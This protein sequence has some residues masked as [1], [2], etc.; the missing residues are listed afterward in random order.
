MNYAYLIGTAIILVAYFGISYLLRRKL[1][2]D[3]TKAMQQEDYQRYQNLI[4]SR[5]ASIMLNPNVLY[6]L[7][8]NHYVMVNDTSNAEKSLRVVNPKKLDTTHMIS[9]YQT[10]VGLALMKKDR[11][12]YEKAITELKSLENDDNRRIIHAL[13]AQFELNRRLN[14]DFDP[15]VIKELEQNVEDAEGQLKG[16]AYMT[17]AKAYHLNKESKKSGAALAKARE[18]LE[19]TP[20]AEIIDAATK[21]PKVLE[22]M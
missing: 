21:D 19:D 8:A 10:T 9:Y 13:V 12:M 1:A 2:D 6:L 4:F 5:R 17:L 11:E 18:L 14:I 22:N 7:R 16:I 15:E 3:I 20:Y